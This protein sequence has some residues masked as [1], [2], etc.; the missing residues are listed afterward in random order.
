M[1]VRRTLYRGS[2]SEGSASPHS[3]S[4]DD[5]VDEF[6]LLCV[7]GNAAGA[8]STSAAA[9]AGFRTFV[10]AQTQTYGYMKPFLFLLRCTG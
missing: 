5:L 6:S 4:G 7:N 8:A 10:D 3:T 9:A 1:P 2:P